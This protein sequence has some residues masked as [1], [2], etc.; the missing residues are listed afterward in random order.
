VP[1]VL[2]G[3]DNELVAG[4][5]SLRR[6]RV[7][8]PQPLLICGEPGSGKTSLL[9]QLLDDA[10]S[11]G[12]R[13]VLARADR[14]DAGVP[15]AALRF[16]LDV[17][18][19]EEDSPNLTAVAASLGDALQLGPAG[20]AGSNRIDVLELLR[21]LLEGWA[22]KQP[23]VFAIDDLHAADADTAAAVFYLMRH[24]RNERVLVVA[25]TRRDPPDLDEALADHLWRFQRDGVLDVIDLRPLGADELGELIALRTGTPATSAVV[26]VLQ[27][28]TGGNPFFLV[29][30]LDALG[31]EGDAIDPAAAAAMPHRVATTVL[32]R[33]FQLGPDPRSVAATAAVLGRIPLERLPVLADLADLDI[34]RT[35]TAFDRL[36]GGR[37]LVEGED[38]FRFSH[39][40]VREAL[41]DDLG[42]A[43]RHRLHAR[44]AQLL[45]ERRAAGDGTEISEVAWHVLEATGGRDTRAAELLVE[46]GDEYVNVAPRTAVM[47]YREALARLDPADPVAASVQIRLS[48]ALTYSSQHVE[49]A[50]VAAAAAR[51]LPVGPERAHAAI[52]EAHSLFGVGRLAEAGAVLDAIIAEPSMRTPRLL[53][54]RAQLSL[55]Q[56]RLDDVR[57]LLAEATER[58]LGR[59]QAIADSLT[60]HLENAAG[61]YRVA[62]E[63]ASRLR[64]TVA[65]ASPAA[66]ANLLLTVATV[67]AVDGDPA[68]AVDDAVTA[69]T[70][71]MALWYQA[72]R[73][74]ALYRLG[75]WDDALGTAEAARVDIEA[76]GAD[77][78]AGVLGPVLAVI[79]AERGDLAGADAARQLTESA[80]MSAFLVLRD[81][82]NALVHTVK[83]EYGAGLAI[84]TSAARREEAQQRC[85]FLTLILGQIV[86]TAS[87]AGD[88]DAARTAN[89][90]LQELPRDDAGVAA[91]MLAL[92]A[93]AVVG[94]DGDAAALAREHAVRYGLRFDAARALARLGTIR[95]DAAV[96]V[97]AYNEFGALGAVHRQRQ[98][99]VELRRLGRRV[100]RRRTTGGLSSVEAQIADLVATGL[101]NRQVA[102]RAGLSPKTVEVYL[103]RI[104]AKT[105]CQSR[106]EL[107][108]AVNSGGLDTG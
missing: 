91:N 43:Q 105:G 73:A 45:A 16:A 39:D 54:Q 89:D 31:S 49:A 36:V 20:D 53:L 78:A 93:H 28:R 41:Y 103:S 8:S 102:A 17:A 51:A 52:L 81:W 9:R 107:A 47:W 96:L 10:R 44:T 106:V 18:L 13:I 6:A 5:E 57:T 59:D 65:G 15:Y 66:Q 77:T 104:Y 48:R 22:F 99:A 30:L 56:E 100:P 19:K 62:A 76:R 46:A 2:V 50:A 25:T 79:R 34:G 21:R 37:I 74:L 12:F 33:V 70:G 32:H 14:A 35:E 84:L 55:W 4:A 71:A 94:A 24:V 61:N 75:R 38:G 60:M 88:A 11:S 82:S 90:R 40:I 85:N 42:P 26:D 7:G 92:M 86:E 27:E 58:G 29:E 101:T 87:E 23:V 83:G 68:L 3:R 72:C 63:L 80:G 95:D 97:E 64:Q 67:G 98:V 69:D 108:L 1:D